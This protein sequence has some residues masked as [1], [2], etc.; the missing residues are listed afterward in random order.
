MNR[1]CDT[2]DKEKCSHI[3]LRNHI[4]ANHM[5]PLSPHHTTPLACRATFSLLGNQTNH[6]KKQKHYWTNILSLSIKVGFTILVFRIISQRLFNFLS[7]GSIWKLDLVFADLDLEAEQ[8]L[9]HQGGFWG[10]C[11]NPV[12]NVWSQKGIVWNLCLCTWQE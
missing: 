7:S 12:Y 10:I 6:W 5:I 4:S 8:K 2:G 1:K 3:D 11:F 9:W